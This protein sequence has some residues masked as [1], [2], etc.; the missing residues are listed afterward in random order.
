MTKP[1][2]GLSPRLM[3]H[4]HKVGDSESWIIDLL[5]NVLTD[6]FPAEPALLSFLGLNLTHPTYPMVQYWGNSM[7][8][9]LAC[10]SFCF[11]FVRHWQGDRNNIVFRN[12]VPTNCTQH[13]CL[14]PLPLISPSCFPFFCLFNNFAC[15]CPASPC[16]PFVTLYKQMCGTCGLHISPPCYS[17]LSPCSFFSLSPCPVSTSA[18]LKD[19]QASSAILF[20]HINILESNS[21]THFALIVFIPSARAAFT[22]DTNDFCVVDNRD[23]LLTPHGVHSSQPLQSSYLVFW[24]ADLFPLLW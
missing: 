10:A 16:L 23:F 14:A 12:G 21:T 18:P 17:L 11:S 5:R 15:P 8:L 6:A 7:A 20:P 4:T 9:T 13:N 24:N 2:E 1:K 22:Q 19:Q 3:L